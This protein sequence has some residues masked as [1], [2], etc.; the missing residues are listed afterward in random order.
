MNKDTLQKGDIV[1]LEITTLTA[2]G[3][4]LGRIENLAVFI[5]GAL[6]EQRASARITKRKKN[7]AEAELLSV[8]RKA[9]Y[10]IQPFC[11]H[12]TE[13][14]GC[15]WQHMPYDIQLKWKKQIVHDA[16]AR[17]GRFENPPVNDPLASPR[18]TFY[19]N[20]MEFAFEADFTG[21][22]KL[23]LRAKGSHSV[24]DICECHL[25]S[26]R[27]VRIVDAARQWANEAPQNAWD[28]ATGTGFFRYLVVRETLYTDQC[29]VQLIT[30]PDNSRHKTG[31]ALGKE[32]GEILRDTIEGITTYIHAERSSKTQVAY[33]EKTLHISGER[34]LTE[35]LGERFF[36]LAPDAF[37]QTNTAA[38]E[39]LTKVAADFAQPEG[40][41]WD[42]YCGVGTMGLP[43]AS[44]A[45][46]VTGIEISQD[47]IA[48]ATENANLQDIHNISF[49]AGDVRKL[50]AKQKDDPD[51]IIVDPPRA[52]MHPDVVA[53]IA[54]RN[55][56]RIVYVSCDPVTQAR[57]LSL[58]KDTYQL[59]CVQPVDMFPH[60]AHI[61]SVALL[62]RR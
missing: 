23:G 22:I 2:G 25:Q 51:I 41:I 12:F 43:M 10:E 15:S 42:L 4:A 40:I 21:N 54:D 44:R 26:E 27:S 18:Q 30:G 58:L 32:L 39:V 57:D 36:K 33:A 37:F 56:R 7:F 35:R 3:R 9:P 11:K 24:I 34:F 29:M 16:L 53:A 52:G 49:I 60:S 1:E 6:P 31:L 8:L 55:P 5:D 45:D 59:Q 38:T 48:F 17:I 46:H 19:R 61:E 20:K 28:P 14:G 47:G 62:I 50:L 13:C